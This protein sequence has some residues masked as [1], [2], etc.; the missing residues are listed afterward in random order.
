MLTNY[1]FLLKFLAVEIVG[2]IEFMLNCNIDLIFNYRINNLKFS[3]K[4]QFI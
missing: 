4:N 1:Q 2:F 3:L